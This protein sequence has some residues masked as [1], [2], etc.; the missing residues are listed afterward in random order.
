MSNTLLIKLIMT[1]PAMLIAAVVVELGDYSSTARIA[2]YLIGI[3]TVLD[4]LENTWNAAFQ[5]YERMELVSYVIVFQ[6]RRQRRTRRRGTG[7]RRRRGRRLE[8]V[9]RSSP[10]QRSSSRCACSAS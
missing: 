2:V 6:R 4:T 9:R 3:S 7:R 5:A 10:W 1:F 8:H